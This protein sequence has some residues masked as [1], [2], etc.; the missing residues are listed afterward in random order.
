MPLPTIQSDKGHSTFLRGVVMTM[1]SLASNK[2]TLEFYEDNQMESF[3]KL[4]E[5]SHVFVK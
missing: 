3:H 5:T 1:E 4:Q 2:E